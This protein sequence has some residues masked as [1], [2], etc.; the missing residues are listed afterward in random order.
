[1]I[2]SQL[3]YV[4]APGPEDIDALAGQAQIAAARASGAA[5]RNFF[6]QSGTIVWSH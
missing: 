6:S 3:E 2:R 1:M 4:I 5:A